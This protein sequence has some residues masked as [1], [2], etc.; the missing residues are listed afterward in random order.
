METKA[1]E[2]EPMRGELVGVTRGTTVGGEERKEGEG[3]REGEGRE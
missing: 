1:S 3:G 2:R